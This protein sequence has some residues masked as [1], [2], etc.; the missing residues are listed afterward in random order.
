MRH[1]MLR[2]C[3]RRVRTSSSVSLQQNCY[4]LKQ[5]SSAKQ[6]Q[7]RFSQQTCSSSL[8][9]KHASQPIVLH[10]GRG[11]PHRLPVAKACSKGRQARAVR[12]ILYFGQ[13]AATRHCWPSGRQPMGRSAECSKRCRPAKQALS[14]SIAFNISTRL[15]SHSLLDTLLALDTVGSSKGCAGGCR[16]M[17]R[18]RASNSA[19][20]SCRARCPSRRI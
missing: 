5:G 2:Q 17:S 19:F 16:D 18:V 20:R 13:S 8:L 3:S 14:C 9:F 11:S 12:S 1:P 6:T 15:A 10:G 4:S 7:T